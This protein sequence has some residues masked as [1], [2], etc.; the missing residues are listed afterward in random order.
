LSFIDPLD[1]ILCPHLYRSPVVQHL[2]GRPVPVAHLIIKVGYYV[3][4]VMSPTLQ[5]SSS[6]VADGPRETSDEI[7]TTAA[8]MYEI[9]QLKKARSG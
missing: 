8:H 7:L 2:K 4:N 9:S 3:F 6:A 1:Y 5:T